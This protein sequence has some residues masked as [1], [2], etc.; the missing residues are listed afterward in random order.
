MNSETAQDLNRSVVEI[1]ILEREH[2]SRD[3]AGRCA[4]DGAGESAVQMLVEPA[5]DEL[6]RESQILHRSPG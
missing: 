6:R 3:R 1:L 5:V 2:R 4:S